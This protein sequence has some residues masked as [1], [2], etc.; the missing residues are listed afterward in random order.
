V[1]YKRTGRPPG[2][3]RKQPGDRRLPPT[4]SERQWRAL[5]IERAHYHK[6]AWPRGYRGGDADWAC[7]ISAAEVAKAVGV[8]RRTVELWRRDEEYSRG[9]MWVMADEL[10]ERMRPEDEAEELR[11]QIRREDELKEMWERIRR[12]DEA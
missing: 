8:T 1:P 6:G 3:P 10:C 4:L 12:E 11:E 7:T 5:A 2:R 9:L